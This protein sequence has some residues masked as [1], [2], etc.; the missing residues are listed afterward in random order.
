VRKHG[1]EIEVHST[2]AQG[3]T[4]TINMTPVKHNNHVSVVK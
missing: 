4:F 2:E 1:G 3:T